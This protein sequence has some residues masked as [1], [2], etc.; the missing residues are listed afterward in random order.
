MVQVQMALSKP[1]RLFVT[2]VIVVGI[3][4]MLAS[5]AEFHSNDLPK[6]LAYLAIALA[7][8]TLKVKLPGITSTMSV[9]F[10]FVLVGIIELTVPETLVIACGAT[11][12]QA[13]VRTKSPP[14]FIQVFFNIA[15]VAI[16]TSLSGVV[17][18]AALLHGVDF[19]DPLLLTAAA[20]AYFAGNSFPV[21]AIIS[22]VEQKSFAKIWKECYFWSFP[23]YIVGA[24]IAEVL[25]IA[26]EH[27][28][29]R[30]AI[31]VLPLVYVI[32]RSYRL[33]L[34]RLESEKSHSEQVA[35]LHLRTIE[36]LSLAI[37][38]KDHRTSEHLRRVQ[39]YALEMG[40]ELGLS[41]DELHA[42]HAAALLHD[43]GKLAVPE[44]IISKPGRLTQEEFEKM[45]IHPIVG[46][47]ILEQI[48]FPYPVVPIVRAHH[49]RWDGT[50]YPYGIKG[51][52][53]PMGA[54]ILAVVDCLDALATDRQYRRALPLEEAMAKIESEAGTAFDPTVIG[55]LKARYHELEQK[56]MQTPV[57]RR[58]LSTSI[59][60]N[61]I[62]PAT[63]LEIARNSPNEDQPEPLQF[64]DSIAAARQEVQSLFELTQDI[65]NSLSL[66]ETLSVLAVRL[67]TIVPYDSIAI[68]VT[69]N[70]RLIPEHVSG[71]DFRLFS[72]LN[73]PL[74]EGLSGWVAA[75]DEWVVNSD[76][77]LESAYSDDPAKISILR[78]ALSV[79]LN[80]VDGAF[81]ALTLYR[82]E[83]D[84]FTKD[85]LRV[86][87]ALRSKVSLAIENALRFRQ[88]ES[89]A[90]TDFLTGLPNARSLFL[91]LE[92]E[93]SRCRR[94]KT[95]VAVLV[96]DLDGFK[97]INDRFGH[98][99]GNRLL[100]MV[101]NSLKEHCR[102]YDYVARMGGD[103][104]VLVLPGLSPRALEQRIVELENAVRDGSVLV[105]GE[106]L[107][108]LSVGA[109]S[110]PEDSPDAEGLL[111]EADRRMY[112]SKEMHKRA[113]LLPGERPVRWTTMTV[114]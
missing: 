6:F 33:Y 80:G 16:A 105:C 109:A 62:A 54:R 84:A 74:G 31:F 95:P 30:I 42:L 94:A 36:A 37:D 102:E 75:N 90:T 19:R 45:K 39:V 93:L 107:V 49:E 101:A 59:P 3:A 73:I 66:S 15:V 78:S 8:S 106:P 96:G 83:K 92:E 76:P 4:A 52:E 41:T 44:H 53:I 47:E 35:A 10:L 43:I 110:Y 5:M 72:S 50:G 65:G 91:H 18:H 68:Y 27:F 70:G 82:A 100:Q 67:K 21:A 13:V 79:P 60:A 34:S 87:L 32:F 11:F 20:C 63:G 17:F 114:Q 98:L 69:K 86:V 111:A 81:G 108:S 46:A 9:N 61:G 55:I 88:A 113:N 89:C 12:L 56:A 48:D 104:F 77:S 28:G 23:Y 58:K 24:G 25:H 7:G 71:D 99:E 57:T 97:Q 1:A 85:N 64:L 51:E 103:E 29:W 40:K 38:A 14:A 22:L 112:G 26:N 2:A